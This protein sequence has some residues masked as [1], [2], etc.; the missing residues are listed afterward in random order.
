MA[1][2]AKSLLVLLVCVTCSCSSI[3]LYPIMSTDIVVMKKGV[4]YTPQQDGFYISNYYLQEVLNAK[5][6]K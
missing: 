2:L 6:K 5:V 4:A 3:R 1:T